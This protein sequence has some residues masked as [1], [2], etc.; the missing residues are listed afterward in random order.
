MDHVSELNFKTDSTLPI[1]YESQKRKN[2]NY[3]YHPSKL[4]F[5]KNKIYAEANQIKF[6]S[7]DYTRYKIGHKKK[8]PLVLLGFSFCI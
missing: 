7:A 8:L 5:E 2:I 4:N 3:I 1:I 6:S